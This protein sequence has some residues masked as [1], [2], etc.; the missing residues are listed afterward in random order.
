MSENYKDKLNVFSG[1]FSLIFKFSE[2]GSSLRL[3]NIFSCEDSEVEEEGES[4][5]NPE[6][7]SK[8]RP[9]RGAHKRITACPHANRRH[10]AKSMCSNCYHK[11]GRHKKAWSCPHQDRLLYAKGM[12]QFCYLQSYHKSRSCKV[13]IKSERLKIQA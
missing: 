13:V 9:A 5:E 3:P 7:V 4:K 6:E 11:S 10:Y 1:M 2:E 8:R 12:C